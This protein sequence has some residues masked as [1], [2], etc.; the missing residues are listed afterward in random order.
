MGSR[1]YRCFRRGFRKGYDVN[2]SSKLFFCFN[3]TQ[4][5]VG[6]KVQVQYQL[7]CICFST[8]GTHRAYFLAPSWYGIHHRCWSIFF[9]ID[10]RRNQG[11]Q[12]PCRVSWTN[13]FILIIWSA[14]RTALVRRIVSNASNALRLQQFRLQSMRLLGI[15][16]S[17]VWISPGCRWLTA[18]W[19]LPIRYA[20][21]EKESMQRYLTS[22][23]FKFSCGFD[24]NKSGSFHC[25]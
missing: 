21:S 18:R 15:S 24:C 13:R 8:K 2:W 5:S 20:L 19:S 1:Q 6:A 11:L 12:L 3:L 23:L 7:D 17:Q 22:C 4:I 25:W 16:H 10:H 14:Q 9:W